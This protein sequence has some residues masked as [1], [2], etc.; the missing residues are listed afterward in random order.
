MKDAEADRMLSLSLG[1]NLHRQVRD[2]QIRGLYRIL[3]AAQVATHTQDGEARQKA[4]ELYGK[5]G[6]QLLRLGEPEPQDVW[7]RIMEG[8]TT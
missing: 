2:V 6:Q 8:T 3:W 4:V 7:T 5:T 1:D